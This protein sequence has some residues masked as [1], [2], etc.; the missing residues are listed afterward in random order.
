MSTELSRFQFFR[1]Q[2]APPTRPPWAID[3]SDFIKQ[4]TGCGDCTQSCPH[5]LIKPGRARYPVIDLSSGAC[6]FCEACLKSCSSGALTASDSPWSIKAKIGNSCLTLNKVTCHT[7]K[8]ECEPEAISFL[9]KAGG[10]LSIEVNQNNCTGCGACIA[11]CPASAI[12]IS[13]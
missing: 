8:D 10:N 12:T 2:S 6:D 4:C 1:G 11:V 7:C 5:H 9:L 3:E 13:K